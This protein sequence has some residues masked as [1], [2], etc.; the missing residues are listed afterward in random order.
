MT[1]IYEES[2]ILNRS[3][4]NVG[5]AWLELGPMLDALWEMLEKEETS[6]GSIEDAGY[7]EVGFNGWC[8]SSY[9]Y[10]ANVFEFIERKKGQKG[11]LRKGD[12]L[13]TITLLVRLCGDTNT[14][15]E[16]AIWPWHD[17][18]CLFVGWHSLEGNRE[19]KWEA[20]HFDASSENI[21]SIRHFDHGLWAWSDEGKDYAYFFALPIFAVQSAKDLMK[22]VIEPLKVLFPSETPREVAE[23]AL[24]GVPV[25]EGKDLNT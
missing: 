17:Q 16:E 10:N 9:S 15:E 19:D 23:R 4:R 7:D 22:Y 12:R 6:L 11:C 13:G 1:D 3:A 25:L 2:R 21:N 18:A 5:S 14:D 8:C 20:G 24:K